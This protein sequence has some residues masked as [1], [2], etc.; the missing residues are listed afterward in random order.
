MELGATLKFLKGTSRP[1][2]AES[3]VPFRLARSF[4]RDC[5]SRWRCSG[6]VSESVT[7]LATCRCRFSKGGVW[8]AL[9]ALTFASDMAGRSM[10]WLSPRGPV[11]PS[12]SR[13]SPPLLETCLAEAAGQPMPLAR[14]SCNECMLGLP[15]TAQSPLQTSVGLPQPY[16]LH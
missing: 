14:Q 5:I 15:S 13:S 9:Q 12:E 11:W 3:W 4:C 10:A 16:G 7:V 6:T 8:T 1:V 2:P